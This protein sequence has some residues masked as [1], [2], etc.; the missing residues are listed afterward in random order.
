MTENNAAQTFTCPACGSKIAADGGAL[1]ERSARLQE[2]EKIAASVPR[3]KATLEKL[4]AQLKR[5][6]LKPAAAAPVVPSSRARRGAKPQTQ[7]QP[8]PEKPAESKSSEGSKSSERKA[9]WSRK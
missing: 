7:K 1:F 3:L 5:E 9:W 2:L 8:E 4:E 6:G